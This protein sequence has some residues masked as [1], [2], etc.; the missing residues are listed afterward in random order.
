M[1]DALSLVDKRISTNR[2]VA[3][4]CR[5]LEPAWQR[6]DL[7][8]AQA[9]VLEGGVVQQPAA[10]LPPSTVAVAAGKAVVPKDGARAVDRI[11]ADQ[12]GGADST[13]QVVR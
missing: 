9:C 10:G 11:N 5:P 3:D 2:H 1:D 12:S 6:V 8:V 7:Q 13:R 4:L